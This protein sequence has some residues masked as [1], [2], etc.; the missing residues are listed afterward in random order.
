MFLNNLDQNLEYINSKGWEND[1]YYKY[2]TCFARYEI[3]CEWIYI[4]WISLKL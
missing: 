1:N 4:T 3:D 2:W